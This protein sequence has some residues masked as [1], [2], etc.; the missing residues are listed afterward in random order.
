MGLLNHSYIVAAITY[1][2]NYNFQ[3]IFDESSNLGLL[4][5]RAATENDR[6]GFEEDFAVDFDH[7]W[8]SFPYDLGYLVTLD[9]EC[10]IFSLNLLKQLLAHT[11]QP[12]LIRCQFYHSVV[13]VYQSRQIADILSRLQ[14]VPSYHHHRYPCPFQSFDRL[15][16]LLL[17][18]VLDT[19]CSQYRQ[20][21]L[22]L[23]GHFV[24]SAIVL[25]FA[26]GLL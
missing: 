14:L 5:W 12:F 15:R 23:L 8:A 20:L 11:L 21:A 3:I 25:F 16:N 10:K 24:Y 4:F 22:Y 19:S 9:D 6:F 13:L 17:Q 7:F 26:Y 2:Q 1:R 18:L